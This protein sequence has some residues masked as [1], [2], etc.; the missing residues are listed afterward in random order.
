MAKN[1]EIPN[2]EL[3]EF[4]LPRVCVMTGSM[5]TIEFRPVKFAWYPR[6]VGSLVICAWPL[7][8]IMMQVMTKR[9]SGKLPFSPPG[10]ERYQ[11]GKRMSIFAVLSFFVGLILCIA[12]GAAELPALIFVGLALALIVPLV[13][14]ICFTRN[15]RINVTK[16][17]DSH[18]TLK[19]PS[20]EAS[21]AFSAHLRGGAAPAG[22]VLGAQ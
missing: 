12:A 16:I 2:G 18:I 3:S 4:D 17:T 15:T 8:L 19:L 22:A 7:A 21:D 14:I 10:W 11:R 13:L 5:E 6:W 1:C 20:N 9:V